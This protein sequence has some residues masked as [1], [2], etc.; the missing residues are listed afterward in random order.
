M[1]ESRGVLLMRVYRSQTPLELCQFILNL[2]K[3]ALSLRCSLL[4]VLLFNLLHSMALIPPCVTRAVA[5]SF[6]PRL[7]LFTDFLQQEE[8]DWMFSSLLAE[9]PWSQKTN[10]RQGQWRCCSHEEPLD[11]FFFCFWTQL[12]LASSGCVC[13]IQFLC[14]SLMLIFFMLLTYWRK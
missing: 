6:L 1:L 12:L 2:P 10:Y 13:W 9:L 3:T 7:R 8:A 14:G 11:S 5:C 4:F